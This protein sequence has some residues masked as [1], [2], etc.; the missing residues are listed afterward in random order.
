MYVVATAVVLGWWWLCIRLR[1]CCGE[2]SG[3]ALGPLVNS[4][5]QLSSSSVVWSLERSC[6]VFC[7]HRVGYVDHV[8][9]GSHS[10][11]EACAC[12]RAHGSRRLQ[13]QSSRL[14][15]QKPLRSQMAPRYAYKLNGHKK[16]CP[17]L[18]RR[19]RHL[20]LRP[21]LRNLHHPFVNL[22]ILASLYLQRPR[23]P[24]DQSP[25]QTSSP[26]HLPQARSTTT[27]TT[28]PLRLRIPT[29]RTQTPSSTSMASKRHCYAASPSFASSP[30]PTYRK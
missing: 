8:Y 6:R 28:R 20:Q 13:L 21:S 23:H 17:Y 5:Q 3:N 7:Q 15:R 29:K 27:G 14:P 2:K 10:S 30:K 26:K 4:C 1:R 22:E 18:R 24:Y 16:L 25:N 19:Q 12:D 11:E 9:G